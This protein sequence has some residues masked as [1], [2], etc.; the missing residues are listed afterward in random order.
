MA[1]RKSPVLTLTN[2]SAFQSRAGHKRV[3]EESKEFFLFLLLSPTAQLV[4]EWEVETTGDVLRDYW[5]AASMFAS[6]VMT[7]STKFGCG[8]RHPTLRLAGK[9]LWRSAEGALQKLNQLL[10]SGSQSVD[11]KIDQQKRISIRRCHSF[12]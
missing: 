7:V 10:R 4:G 6:S 5:T 11:Q 8:L 9:Y 2:L 1:T 12:D 3:P